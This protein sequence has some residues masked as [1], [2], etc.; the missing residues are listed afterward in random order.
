MSAAAF[1]PPV[2]L[3]IS[4]CSMTTFSVLDISISLAGQLLGA[5]EEPGA[6]FVVQIHALGGQ[7]CGMKGWRVW[8][9]EAAAPKLG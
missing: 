3:Y 5:L 2:T 4:I 1:I 9:L 8:D 7:S 6:W